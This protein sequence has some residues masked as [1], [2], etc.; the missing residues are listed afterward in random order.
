MFAWGT[1]QM[2]TGAAAPPGPSRDDPGRAPD[3]PARHRATPL[4]SLRT[5][6][7][8]LFLAAGAALALVTFAVFDR[9]ARQI[10]GHFATRYAEREALLQQSRVSALVER[11]V[12]LA[13]KLADDPLLRRWATHEEDRA[14]EAQAMAQLESYRRAFRTG[15]FFIALDGTRSYYVYDPSP[16]HPGVRRT[17]LRPGVPSDRWYFEALRRREPFLL[18]VDAN[19]TLGAVKVWINV[20]LRDDAGR[21]V[22]VGGT[23]IDLS[24]FLDQ[25]RSRGPADAQSVLVDRQGILQAHWNRAYVERNAHATSD[26]DKITIYALLPAADAARLRAALDGLAAGRGG[27]VLTTLTLEGRPS[28]VAVSFMKGIGWYDLV[29]LDASAI[30]SARQLLP[31]LLAMAAGVA[32]LLVVLVLTLDRWLMRPIAG[33]TA[34]ARAV[35]AGD[36]RARAPEARRDELGLLAR[37]FNGMTATILDYTLRLQ[38]KVEERTR[39]L[40]A[41]NA[42]LRD[43]QERIEESL[44]YAQAIQASILPPPAQL[45][46]GLGP[47]ALVYLPRDVVGGDFYDHVAVE[48]GAL[49]AVVDCTGHG[50]PGAFVSLIASAVLRQAFEAGV[51]DPAELLACLNRGV[52]QARHQRDVRGALDAGLD[53]LACR[54]DHRTRTVA[55]AGAGLPAFVV[56]GGAVVEL[57]GDRHRPGY[58]DSDPDHRFAAHLLHPGDGTR[59]YLATDGVLDHAGGEKGFG[60][61]TSRLKQLLEELAPVPMAEQGARLEAAL[62]AWAGPRPQRDDLTILGFELHWR[63]PPH[64]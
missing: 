50:V 15:T 14:L 43:S 18:N 19:T 16:A 35:A 57:A 22:G 9:A 32:A 42:A 13:T 53:V 47:H 39:Q 7:L 5:R 63:T 61:G 31:L 55:I 38:E 49:T 30:F 45:E 64:D 21:A 34:A 58:R 40:A 56:E 33:L 48:G 23:G 20:V 24:E 60:L 28:L 37:T 6:F 62:R 52:R 1:M 25:L 11:E 29:A 51:A 3:A 12:A 36:Y 8:A 26:A 17:T 2:P 54:V 41:S 46:A 10:A 27:V 4:R 44:R 59:V